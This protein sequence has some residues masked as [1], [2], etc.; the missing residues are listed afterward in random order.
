MKWIEGPVALRRRLDHSEGTLATVGSP[1]TVCDNPQIDHPL[2]L[3]S[4]A[5]ALTAGLE[6]LSR[7]PV[8]RTAPERVRSGG[9]MSLSF[10]P[11]WDAKAPGVSSKLPLNTPSW[12]DFA[13][14]RA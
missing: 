10:E 13:M 2:A 7:K 9:A 5:G 11:E 12:F 14:K 6:E 1:S 3:Q 4:T 8:G